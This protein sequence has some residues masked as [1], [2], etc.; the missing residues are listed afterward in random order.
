ML[1]IISGVFASKKFW[2]FCVSMADAGPEP[3]YVSEHGLLEVPS[4][5]LKG[6]HI[7]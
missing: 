3:P 2:T 7:Y 5:V 4:P 1:I 6:N